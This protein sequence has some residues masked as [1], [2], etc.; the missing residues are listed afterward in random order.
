MT[1]TNTNRPTHFVYVVTGDGDDANWTQIAAA[2][3]HRSGDGM[4]FIVPPGIMVSGKLVI[5]AA[6]SA[7]SAQA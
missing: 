7:N 6:K 2:W 4:N 5:R 3:E 1:K